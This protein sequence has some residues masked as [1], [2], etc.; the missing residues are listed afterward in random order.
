MD[1]IEGKKVLLL[2]I[3]NTSR[4]DDGLGWAFA[5]HLEQKRIFP[6][7]IFLRFQL[8][9][10]DAELCSHYPFVVFVD[11]WKTD[12][13][14]PSVEFCPC[15]PAADAVFTTHAVSPQGILQICQD[16]YGHT[17]KAYLLL[18]KG[19]SWEFGEGLSTQGEKSLLEGCAFFEHYLS[20]SPY[21]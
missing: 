12:P 11:A 15:M 21:F 6:G 10:E 19:T 3:G 20:Q 4:G 17:P 1:T 7:D 9:I 8:Q 18:L 13:G 5:S 16:L 14:T 2:A